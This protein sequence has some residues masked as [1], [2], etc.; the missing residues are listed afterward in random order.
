M[1]IYFLYILVQCSFKNISLFQ[2]TSAKHGE[3]SRQMKV[4]T[5]AERK[6][7]CQNRLISHTFYLAPSD[8]ISLQGNDA[9]QPLRAGLEC[10]QGSSVSFPWLP[11][12][13]LSSNVPSV[14][15]SLSLSLSPECHGINA[16]LAL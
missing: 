13:L 8:I 16:Q 12:L 11:V 15:L 14:L 7:L 1:M 10:F 2:L 3:R 4:L 5:A 6:L 9:L